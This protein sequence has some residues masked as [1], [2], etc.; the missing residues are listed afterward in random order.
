[1]NWLIKINVALSIMLSAPTLMACRMV[2]LEKNTPRYIRNLVKRAPGIYLADAIE[3]SEKDENF[4]FKVAEVIKGEKKEKLVVTASPL[5]LN[6]KDKAFIEKNTT[7]FNFHRSPQFWSDVITG[8]TVFSSDCRLTPTF[9]I[10]NRYLI[11]LNEP[12]QTKSFEL[13]KSRKDQWYQHVMDIV[14]PARRIKKS[15]P[16][17]SATGTTSTQEQNP[18]TNSSATPASTEAPAPVEEKKD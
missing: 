8:R 3:Y 9:Q 7:D 17:V 4:T 5:N 18:D 16:T 2:S 1:M 15:A 6:S 12:Y 11:I 14:Y 10:G 13:I